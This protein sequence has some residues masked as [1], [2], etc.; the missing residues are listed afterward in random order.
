[1][2]IDMSFVLLEP[3]LYTTLITPVS[4]PGATLVTVGSLGIPVNALYDGAQIVIDGGTVNQEIVTVTLVSPPTNQFTATFANTHAI[5]AQVV[6]A[7]FPVQASS[8]D[9]FFRPIIFS[10]RFFS[11]DHFFRPISRRRSS[12]YSPAVISG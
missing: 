12:R 10:D 7:T 5:G 8:G 11:A 9:Y 2:M 1:M 4:A 3:I 6:G